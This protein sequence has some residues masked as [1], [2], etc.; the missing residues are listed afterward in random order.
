MLVIPVN[1]IVLDLN[2]QTRERFALLTSTLLHEG[3]RGFNCR[4]MLFDL[5]VLTQGGGVLCEPS[6]PNLKTSNP[7]AR[8]VTDLVLDFE[9]KGGFN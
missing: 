4:T 3:K 6:Y 2:L 9:G 8:F 7:S 5:G 1:H